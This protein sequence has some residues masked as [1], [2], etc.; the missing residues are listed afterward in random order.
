LLTADHAISPKTQE[1]LLS[2]QQKGITLVLASGRSYL[3]LMPDAL[4]LK[5]D[6]YQGYLIDVN[7]SS[8]YDFNS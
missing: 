4:K 2:L 7:G 5:M 3:R 8:I 1:L 6:S